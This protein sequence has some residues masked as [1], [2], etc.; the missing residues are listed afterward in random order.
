MKK[1]NMN[2]KKFKKQEISFDKKIYGVK[3][4]LDNTD[5][6]QD[7]LLLEI[8]DF[9]KD[10]KQRNSSKEK[11]IKDTVDNLNAFYDGTE[12]V[13]NPFKIGIFS[14]QLNEYTG[15]QGLQAQVSGPTSLKILSPKHIL[16]RLQIPLAQ[17]KVVNILCIKRKKLLRRYIA[18]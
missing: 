9:N 12:M 18:I 1:L 5:K 13:L 7:G 6:D 2:Q 11:Q 16:Q 3:I 10:K 15:N 14:L 8:D 4:T 17:V